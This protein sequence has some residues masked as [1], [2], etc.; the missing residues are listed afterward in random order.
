MVS[1]ARILYMSV[2]ILLETKYKQECLQPAEISRRAGIS[3]FTEK[4][5][6]KRRD[7]L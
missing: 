2:D 7:D 5:F 3:L 6:E 4:E 1:A